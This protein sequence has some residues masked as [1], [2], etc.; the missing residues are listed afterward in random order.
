VVLSGVFRILLCRVALAV[1]WLTEIFELISVGINITE[2]IVVFIV[3]LLLFGPEQL[4]NLARQAGKISGEL[5]KHSNALRREFYNTVYPP[6]IANDLRS[7][8][9]SLAALK[10]ELLAP[11]VGSSAVTG[12]PGGAISGRD[13]SGDGAELSTVKKDA[14]VSSSSAEASPSAGSASP[15]STV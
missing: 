5:R 11:P 1:R 13:I 12:I 4:P 14:A 15:T 10:G 7:G 8:A 6:D 3:A 9:R 2:I